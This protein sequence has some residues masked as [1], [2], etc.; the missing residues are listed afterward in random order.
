M[1]PLHRLLSSALL[2]VIG[3][4]A[5]P[6]AQAALAFDY[7]V[8][9]LFV[10]FDDTTFAS[11]NARYD[12]HVD[13]SGDDGDSALGVLASVRTGQSNFSWVAG[14]YS[15]TSDAFLTVSNVS[16]PGST[17]SVT[18]DLA[19][20]GGTRGALDLGYDTAAGVLG[21]SIIQRNVGPDGYSLDLR[22][23]G[24]GFLD[25]GRLFVL[26]VFVQ[27]DWTAAHGSGPGQLEFISI[28]PAFTITD[29]FASYSAGLNAT[30]FAANGWATGDN[31]FGP[32]LQFRLHGD[33]L[34]VP[35]PASTLMLGA[36]L[37]VVALRRR[38]LR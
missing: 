26:V 9:V 4:C 20:S 32:D 5:L 15:A 10:T 38:S 19:L 22:G 18:A 25:G 28:D 17:G 12:Y 6:A 27:G 34:P 30:V 35:E 24:N 13:V 8:S 11:A 2:L 21:P 31:S 14:P 7:R 29:N 33:A 37:L 3:A 16:D 36:G 23:G 1:K